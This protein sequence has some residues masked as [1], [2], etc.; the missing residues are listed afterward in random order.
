MEINTLLLQLDT[1]FGPVQ[2]QPQHD[3]LSELI[4]TI[5]SHQTTDRN[6]AHAFATLTHP[7]P[8]WPAI[9]ALPI[10]EII[11]KIRVAG[12]AQ[13]KAQYILTTLDIVSQHDTPYSIDFL[14]TMHVTDA[15][16]WLMQLPGIGP[17]TAACVLL[18]AYGRP[19]TPVDTHIARVCQRLQLVPATHAVHIQQQLESLVPDDRK[20][21]FHVHMIQLGRRVCHARQPLCELCPLASACPS[22]LNSQHSHEH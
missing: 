17:K 16:Q 3:G 4:M 18:F 6:S 11:E 7:T 10:A 12:L 21:A 8:D 19:V 5:L 15:M 22:A 13:R 1:Y 14:A 9:H 20:Y 2:W